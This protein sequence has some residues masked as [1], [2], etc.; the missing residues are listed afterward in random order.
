[1][2][3]R[4]ETTYKDTL[5]WFYPNSGVYRSQVDGKILGRDM[6]EGEAHRMA[7]QSKVARED[8]TASTRR[9]LEALTGQDWDDADE[10]LRIL[11]KGAAQGKTAD[12]RLLLQTLGKLKDASGAIWD[13]EGICPTCLGKG[14][15]T[16]ELETSAALVLH[17][18]LGGIVED[19]SD[20]PV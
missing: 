2:T 11:A 16:V 14:G 3:N 6:P 12:H 18:L 7:D 13:G 19:V 5:A 8:V 20:E 9:L 1:M 4:V 15:A 10:S 17:G